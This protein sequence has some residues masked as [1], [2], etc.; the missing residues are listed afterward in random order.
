MVANAFK[1][2]TGR[3]RQRQAHLSASSKDTYLH[4]FQGYEGRSSLQGLVYP[5]EPGTPSGAKDDH[6]L[7]ILLILLF[8]CWD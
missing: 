5:R 7:L 1:T 4:K 3:L 2:S 6:D 8:K